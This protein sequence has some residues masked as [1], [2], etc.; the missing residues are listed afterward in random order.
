MKIC[1]VTA[2]RA[3]FGLLSGLME[4]IDSDSDLELQV[5]VTGAHLM[6]EFGHT[7]DAVRFAGFRVDAEVREI[8]AA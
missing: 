2:T 3:E 4:L 6:E 8:T 1:V 7:V 5:V